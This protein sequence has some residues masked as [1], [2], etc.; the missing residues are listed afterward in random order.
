MHG[1]FSAASFHKL[2][3]KTK[4]TQQEDSELRKVVG[5]LGTNDWQQVSLQMPGRN[6]R[7]CRDRWLNYLSPDVTNGPWTPAEEQLLMDKYDE[8]GATWKHIAMFFP[9]RTD[10]NIKSRWQ[11][12]QR[13][14]Q[15]EVSHHLLS[16]R[17][18]NTGVLS[19]D[20]LPVPFGIA[21]VRHAHPPSPP[22]ANHPPSGEDDTWNSLLMNDDAGMD[23][24]LDQWY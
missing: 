20:P 21:P 16:T 12:M 6:A 5:E 18:P 8:F 3:P 9:T 7:Q 19:S 13:H 23:G 14:R 2:H 10:I 11:L 1:L 22:P 15:K 24:I 17:M 4:F